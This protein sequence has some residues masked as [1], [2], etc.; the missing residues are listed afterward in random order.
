MPPA[1]VEFAATVLLDGQS[2]KAARRPMDPASTGIGYV[3]KV[4][5]AI[6]DA[7]GSVQL[8]P[9]NVSTIH[10][11]SGASR[12]VADGMASWG[13]N[14]W[15]CDPGLILPGPLVTRVTL[16]IAGTAATPGQGFAEYGG[17]L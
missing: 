1:P 2:Y 6:Q 14:I 3:P 5:W 8:D 16:P 13:E 15:G 12:Q 4:A 17:D 7:A 11:G 10:H 9:I